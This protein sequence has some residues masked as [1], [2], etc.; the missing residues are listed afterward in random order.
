MKYDIITIGGATEDI[1]F[2]TN[3]GILIDNKKDPLRQKL[4][5]FEYGAKIKI[6]KAVSTFGGGAANA[7]V[8][9]SRLGFK[10]A[11]LM[12][13]GDDERGD[14]IL[15]HLQKEKISTEF[16]QKNK[17]LETGYSFILVGPSN[18]HIVFSNRG[19]NE[20][21]KVKSLPA[22]KAGAKLKVAKWVFISSLSGDWNNNLKEIFKINNSK[23]AWNPGHRQIIGGIK[24][25]KPFLAKTQVFQVNKDEALELCMSSDKINGKDKACIYDTEHLLKI[26]KSYGP[27]IVVITEGAKG[28]K[29]F[30]G[31]KIYTE[32]AVKKKVLNTTGVGDA[33]GSSFVAGLE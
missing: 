31:Q 3:E 5:A 7:A 2:F 24:L 10:T 14:K 8:C 13:I 28:A 12:S 29:C 18:E 4:L 27:K 30:D 33:F 9:F 19:A 16:I 1:S 6:D 17:K 32:K 11:S 23:I 21:L 20:K 25:L 26:L 15:K 22:G